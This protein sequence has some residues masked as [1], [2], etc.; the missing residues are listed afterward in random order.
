MLNNMLK[1]SQV[2]WLRIFSFGYRY[3]NNVG[4]HL[5][6][7]KIFK[8]NPGNFL[9]STNLGNLYMAMGKIS[10]AIDCFE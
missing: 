1:N 5:K 4:L 6:F 2:Q 9:L 7:M 3:T 8:L 10:K